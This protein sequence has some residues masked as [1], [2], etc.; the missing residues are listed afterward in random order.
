MAGPKSA[1]AE[2]AS[3]AVEAARAMV[4]AAVVVAAVMAT[5]VKRE[6]KRSGKSERGKMLR[7]LLLLN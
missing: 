3:E 5:A 1:A 4:S 6:A 2:W 7:R